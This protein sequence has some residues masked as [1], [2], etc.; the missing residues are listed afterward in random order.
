MVAVNGQFHHN[1]TPPGLQGPGYGV[2]ISVDFRIL[3]GSMITD[4]TRGT[5]DDLLMDHYS[6]VVERR[7]GA[8]EII[9]PGYRFDPEAAGYC[10]RNRYYLPFFGRWLQRDPIGYAGG[11]K[12]YECVGAQADMAVDPKGGE[13]V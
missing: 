1:G 4:H 13:N 8:N 2:G 12:L 9:Y 3:H 6:L 7:A 11:I 10:V 5:P